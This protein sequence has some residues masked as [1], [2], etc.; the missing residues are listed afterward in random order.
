MHARLRL[1]TMNQKKKAF[2]HIS[3]YAVLGGQWLRDEPVLDHDEF[4]TRWQHN[5]VLCGRSAAT[6]QLEVRLTLSHPVPVPG[7]QAAAAPHA[8]ASPSSL[9]DAG[10]LRDGS[11]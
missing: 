8:V 10:R 11:S 1:V 2:S 3:A 9:P 5:G 7:G 6:W 4:R